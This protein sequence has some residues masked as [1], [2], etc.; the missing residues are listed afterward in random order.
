VAPLMFAHVVPPLVLICHCTVGVGLPMAVAVNVAVVPLFT[1]LEG[2]YSLE[3]LGACAVAALRQMLGR[4][5]GPDLLGGARSVEPDLG[6]LIGT[7]R[8][9]HPL[10][11]T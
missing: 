5:P 10:F 7:I 9:R 8:E 3:A 2:G 1:V 6:H 11:G 4:D